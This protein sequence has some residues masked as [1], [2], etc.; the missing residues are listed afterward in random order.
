MSEAASIMLDV[1]GAHLIDA[2]PYTCRGILNDLTSINASMGILTV[3]GEYYIQR[4]TFV[5]T[6]KNN[7]VRILS[8]DVGWNAFVYFEY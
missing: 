7:L 5:Y 2:G 3:V 6:L 8:Q 1:T 4:A